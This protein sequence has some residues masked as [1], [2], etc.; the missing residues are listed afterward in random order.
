MPLLD[1]NRGNVDDKRSA[2]CDRY[3]TQF[4]SI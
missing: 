4:R 1:K 2:D 3:N